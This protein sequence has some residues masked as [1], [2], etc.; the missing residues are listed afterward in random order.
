MIRSEGDLRQ[1]FID[2]HGGG[3][4]GT[5]LANQ[6]IRLLRSEIVDEDPRFDMLMVR[7]R[8]DST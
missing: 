6:L 4:I 1:I 3:E 2:F 5:D 7:L 8:G